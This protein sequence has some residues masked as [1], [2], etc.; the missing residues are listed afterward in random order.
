MIYLELV[1][2]L[3]LH[4]RLIKQSG[5]LPGVRDQGQVEAA[6]AQPR[7]AFGGADLYPTLIDK[8]AALAFA[9]VRNHPFVDGNK[10]IGHAAMET[11]LVCNGHEIQASTDEQEALILELAAGWMLREAFTEWVRG[12]LVPRK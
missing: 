8:A 3:E 9:L 10:R 1:D 7:M 11:F 4:R 12:Y 6:L 5:G 2:V